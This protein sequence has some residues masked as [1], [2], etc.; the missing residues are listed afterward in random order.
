MPFPAK[1]PEIALA[2]GRQC[3]PGVDQL[4][5]EHRNRGRG[6]AGPALRHRNLAVDRPVVA[7]VPRARVV[8]ADVAGRIAVAVGRREVH[9]D[10]PEHVER[11]GELALS[12]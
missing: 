4:A 2:A 7:Q 10:R 5:L 3:H 6:I 9:A 12:S 11:V 8:V 1:R